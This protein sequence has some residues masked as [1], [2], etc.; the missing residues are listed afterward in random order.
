MNPRQ[1]AKDLVRL[2]ADERTPE[3]ERMVSAIKA[4]G[5]IQEHGLL[6]SPLDGI[7]DVLRGEQA[8]RTVKAASKLY[9]AFTDPDVLGALKGIGGMAGK[10]RESAR[11]RR[12]RR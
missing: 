5:L 3:K 2:A 8:Q 10:A 7:G 4:V 6:D 9:D 11:E 12:R 1:K